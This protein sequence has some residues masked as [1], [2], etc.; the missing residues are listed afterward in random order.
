MTIK[1]PDGLEG[2]TV[3]G[4][5]IY[6]D[7]DSKEKSYF[8]IPGSPQPQ[9]NLND[10]PDVEIE[11]SRDGA[12][13]RLKTRWAANETERNQLIS[14]IAAEKNISADR[15]TLSVGMLNQPQVHLTIGDGSQIVQ[16]LKPILA[17]ATEP[18]QASL[19][20]TITAKE[21]GNALPAFNGD[22]GHLMVT[23]TGL[24]MVK[25]YIKARIYG[26]LAEDIKVLVPE[27]EKKKRFGWFGGSDRENP[28][29]QE[30]KREDC[31]AQ[32]E[33]SLNSGRLLFSHENSSNVPEALRQ[34]VDQIVKEKVTDLLY[35]KVREVIA[36]DVVPDK[37]QIDQSYEKTEPRTYAI[38]STADVGTWLQNIN[39]TTHIKDALVPIPSPDRKVLDTTV[40]DTPDSGFGTGQPSTGTV[41]RLSFQPEDFHDFNDNSIARSIDITGGGQTQTLQGPDFAPITLPFSA[42]GALIIETL[43]NFG[44]SFVRQVPI[45]GSELA[46]TP[47]MLGVVQIVVDGSAFKAKAAKNANIQ[48]SYLPTSDGVR[49]QRTIRFSA[50][51]EKWIKRWFAVTRSPDLGGSIQWSWSVMLASGKSVNQSQIGTTNPNLVLQQTS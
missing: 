44:S 25:A 37:S 47:D 5:F 29:K 10:E 16:A 28:A 41:V 33:K 40:P 3:R 46:L 36:Q 50:S 26:D 23:Y 1:V 6:Q 35:Q 18:F 30:V 38:E 8:Y 11:V 42:T 20:E 21:K 17:S 24:L 12:N 43:F 19:Q 34:E 39:G 22:T 51:D 9:R 32:I 31:Q 7:A 48:V 45:S 13:I 2:F 4:I 14:R 27:K 49:E 15:I